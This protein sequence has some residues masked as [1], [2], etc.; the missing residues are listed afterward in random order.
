[1]KEYK[2]GNHTFAIWTDFGHDQNAFLAFFSWWLDAFSTLWIFFQY[3]IT[4]LHLQL[5]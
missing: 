2:G 1:M 5:C 4:L 3:C